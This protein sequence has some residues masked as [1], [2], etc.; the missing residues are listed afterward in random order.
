MKNKIP[1]RTSRGFTV[2]AAGLFLLLST[3]PVRAQI[4][5]P[6]SQSRSMAVEQDEQD[7]KIEKIKKK[8]DSLVKEERFA[9]AEKVCRKQPK[10]RRLRYQIYLLDYYLDSGRIDN[11]RSFSERIVSHSD[12][13]KAALNTRLGLVN[14]R[15]GNHNIARR[16]LENGA[17]SARRGSG[18][19]KLA[20]LALGSGE[21]DRALK[22][23]E[24]AVTDYSIQLKTLFMEW[25]QADAKEMRRCIKQLRELR[26]HRPKNEKQL[27]LEKTLQGAVQYC[28]KMKKSMFHF[29]C[30]EDIRETADFDHSMGMLGSGNSYKSFVKNQYVYEYQLFQEKG[31][32]T[33]SR[34]LLEQNGIKKK[35]PDA[36]LKITG[37]KYKK[38][39]FAP[40][41]L[42]SGAA[43]P[44]YYYTLAGEEQ[45]WDEPAVVV[46]ALP[47]FYGDSMR[48]YGKVWISKTDFSVMK[49]QFYPKSIRA[50][51]LIELRSVRH[52]A[53][54]VVKFYEEF[55]IKKF[56]IRFP[57]RYYLEEAY[58]F[59]AR[60]KFVRSELDAKFKDYMFFVVGSEVIE[61]KPDIKQ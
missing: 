43:H 16:Y 45:L 49:I 9:A 19:A 21:K 11:A 32:V 8:L 3:L 10:K 50:S 24:T 60:P 42:V 48:L 36:E 18:F 13:G 53:K 38:L 20:D 4:Q 27:L 51:D 6:F 56:G 15:Q 35:E 31:K 7:D 1:K 30:K 25:V 55:E 46:E 28:E 37:M 54:P 44:R 52:N 58:L 41:S 17:P 12:E 61:A 26:K 14:L 34:T 23:Y 39:I 29:F 2:F 47:V 33:E 59:K 57:S 22:D 5:P 40:I